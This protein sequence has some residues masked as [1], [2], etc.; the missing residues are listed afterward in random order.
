M[1]INADLHPHAPRLERDHWIN[2]AVC[3]QTDPEIFFPQY[4]GDT[5]VEA[6]QICSTCPVVQECQQ[7]ADRAEKFQTGTLHGMYGGET[8]DERA[9]RRR[10]TRERKTPQ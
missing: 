2:R 1:S 3:T 8:P 7:Y 5:Y 6:R 9:A 10:K 4:K